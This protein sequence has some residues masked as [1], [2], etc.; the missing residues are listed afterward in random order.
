MLINDDMKRRSVKMLDIG[1]VTILFFI[2]GYYC[3]QIL[4]GILTKFFGETK[5][6]NQ[7]SSFNLIIQIVLQ[8]AIIGIISYV[9]R[10]IIEL[11]PFPLNGYKGYDHLLLKELRGPGLL[12]FFFIIF[13]YNL[14]EKI[15]II[16]SRSLNLCKNKCCIKSI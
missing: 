9:G 5:T 12:T 7:V 1:Y 8:I 15:S 3:A 4:E 6:Y 16:K 11:I 13:S 2:F 14:Q 10:N